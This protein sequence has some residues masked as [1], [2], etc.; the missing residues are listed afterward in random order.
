MQP[1]QT[2]KQRSQRIE[3]DYYRQR[4]GFFKWKIAITIAAL[5]VGVSALG[6]AMVSGGGKMANPG[7]VAD[8][9]A[10]FEQDC[11]QCHQAF[12]PIGSDAVRSVSLLGVSET[13]AIANTQA[14][15]T[16]CHLGETQP[17]GDHDRSKM[18][19]DWP[20]LD[21]NSARCHADHQGRDHDLTVVSNQQC[22]IC[23]ARLA[24]VCK[25]GTQVVQLAADNKSIS[26]FTTDHGNFVSLQGKDPGTITFDHAQHLKP[27]QSGKGK[28]VIR[29]RDLEPELRE[30]YRMRM[31][32][33]K[34]TGMEN[35]DT[36][37]NGLVQLDCSSCHEMAGA[38]S[39][40]ITLRSDAEL[41]RYMKPISVRRTLPGL[42]PHEPRRPQR[43]HLAHSSRGA[44]ERNRSVAASENRCPG[45][46]PQPHQPAG[47]RCDRPASYAGETTERQRIL[48]QWNNASV[49]ANAR[50]V[51]KE[52]CRKCHED[53]LIQ[54]DQSIIA[55]RSPDA[56]PLIPSRWLANGVYD[57]AAHRSIDC[58]Y[59]HRQA[60]EPGTPEA[61]GS[62]QTKVMI[63][64]IESCAGCHRESGTATPSDLLSNGEPKPV[65][66]GQSLWASDSCTMCHR[67]HMQTSPRAHSL[68]SA[69]VG[70]VE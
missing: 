50:E 18:D 68:I 38:P 15:C 11:D 3:L 7:P 40:A 19:G 30:R 47:N 67:Y 31:L 42:S 13:E 45:S 65:F 6:Y 35:L 23:H 59:C 63:A 60:Y 12:S 28:D 5:V 44:L 1:R 29:L 52:Q 39:G 56:P 22:A 34:A 61:V 26:S 58:V 4:G 69:A 54:S 62:D 14:A 53:S 41:G 66:G 24:D 64:G 17:I 32:Q 49:L 16:K 37:D 20:L 2:G 8:G 21:Q 36:T 27:G 55:A 57:H 51:L 70:A 9:H 33:L 10:A 48:D 43:R 25:Q 46:S